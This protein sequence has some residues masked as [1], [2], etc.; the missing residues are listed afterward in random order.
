MTE[1]GMDFQSHSA[2][3]S[4]QYIPI[5]LQWSLQ[6]YLLGQEIGDITIEYFSVY[7][8][9]SGTYSVIVG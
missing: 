1:E 4:L 7:C 9:L 3:P 5:P 2:T 6:D 8:T